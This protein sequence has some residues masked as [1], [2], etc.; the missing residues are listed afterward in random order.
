MAANYIK[1][2]I[3]KNVILFEVIISVLPFKDSSITK[4]I[5]AAGT[6]TYTYKM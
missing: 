5:N 2:N 6:I 1:K 3:Y 4:Y